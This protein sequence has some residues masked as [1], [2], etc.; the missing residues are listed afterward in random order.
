MQPAHQ[1]LP[2]KGLLTPLAAQLGHRRAI[3]PEQVDAIDG[4]ALSHRL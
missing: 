2:A 4:A 1:L 3:K